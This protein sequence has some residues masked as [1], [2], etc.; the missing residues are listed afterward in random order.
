MQFLCVLTVVSYGWWARHV[1]KQAHGDGC[2]RGDLLGLVAH[3][4][5]EEMEVT[6]KVEGVPSS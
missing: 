3:R 2:V 4:L 5:W 6:Y 1:F